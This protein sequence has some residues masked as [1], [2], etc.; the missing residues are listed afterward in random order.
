MAY[1]KD[2]GWHMGY[3]SE[4]TGDYYAA[5]IESEKAR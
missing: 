1:K 2:S 4:Q 5:P 3:L